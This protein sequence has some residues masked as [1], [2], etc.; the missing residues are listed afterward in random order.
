MKNISMFNSFELLNQKYYGSQPGET[1]VSIGN[2]IE[3][4]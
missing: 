3:S 1:L 4:R 2:F